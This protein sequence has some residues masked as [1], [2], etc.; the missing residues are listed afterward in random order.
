VE[1]VHLAGPFAVV[2][3]GRR[4]LALPGCYLD[5]HPDGQEIPKV[6]SN[7]SIAESEFRDPRPFGG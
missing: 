4:V 5:L 2:G 7:R 1:G 6:K 3:L